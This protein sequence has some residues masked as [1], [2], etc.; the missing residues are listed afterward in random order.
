MIT[1][2]MSLLRKKQREIQ[3]QMSLDMEQQ[4]G[5]TFH[6]INCR[7]TTV[8]KVQYEEILLVSF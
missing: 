3:T 7:T 1:V 8:N 4:N 2:I 5:G 6:Q